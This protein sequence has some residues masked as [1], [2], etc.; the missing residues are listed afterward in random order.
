M[1]WK[2]KHDLAVETGDQVKEPL[3]RRVT[4]LIEAER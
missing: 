1:D 2:G 3:N 4:I